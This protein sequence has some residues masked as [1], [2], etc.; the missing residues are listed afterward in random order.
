MLHKMNKFKIP[1]AVPHP[2]L[3]VFERKTEADFNRKGVFFTNKKVS[4]LKLNHFS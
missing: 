4:L 2:V 1:L 3:P